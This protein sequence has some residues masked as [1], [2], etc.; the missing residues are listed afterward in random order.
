MCLC[1]YFARISSLTHYIVFTTDMSK[2]GTGTPTTTTVPPKKVVLIAK[3]LCGVASDMSIR[4]LEA[5]HRHKS[6]GSDK[7]EVTTVQR[8]IAIATCC[9]HACNYTDYVGELCVYRYMFV[10]LY[11]YR[12]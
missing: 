7:L 2:S 12:S 11:L 4:S 9:H 1:V 8:G 10:V 5:L 3:H 6:G